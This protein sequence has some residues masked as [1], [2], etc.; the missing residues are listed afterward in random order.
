[1]RDAGALSDIDG[2]DGERSPPVDVPTGRPA[3]LIDAAYGLDAALPMLDGAAADAGVDARPADGS[4]PVGQDTALAAS[5][6]AQL[7]SCRVVGTGQFELPSIADGY[8]R[9]KA[10]C[11]LAADCADVRAT[12]CDDEGGDLFDCIEE[13]SETSFDDGY[14]CDGRRLRRE[15]LCDLRA[16]CPSGQDELDCGTFMC[17][18]GRLVPSSRARCNGV[19]DCSDGS[20][21]A[22][23]AAWCAQ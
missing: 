11:V 19:R 23:C 20:D 16:H 15:W 6:L 9:C 8:A 3:P 13:C 5:V 22:G 18:D 14:A 4:T 10:Q 12:Y 17:S 7:R 1:V 21:E 2:G